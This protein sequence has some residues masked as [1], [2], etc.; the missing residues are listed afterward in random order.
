MVSGSGSRLAG[1][2]LCEAVAQ[3]VHFEDVDVMG[4]AVEQGSGEPLVAEDAG[5]LVEGWPA[6]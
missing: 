2:A 4:Q 6:P 5:P 1:A 3:A